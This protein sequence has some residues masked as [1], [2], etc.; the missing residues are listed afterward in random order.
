MTTLKKVKKERGGVLVENFWEK[1]FLRV[2]YDTLKGFW[3]Y[4]LG[5]YV[6]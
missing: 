3:G 6:G 5:E 1:I 4:T 2:L